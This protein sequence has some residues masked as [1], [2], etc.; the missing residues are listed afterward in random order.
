MG[1]YP[2]SGLIQL[3]ALFRFG[4]HI[5]VVGARRWSTLICITGDTVDLW[6]Q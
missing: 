3:D 5:S 6:N 4:V 1:G 2:H